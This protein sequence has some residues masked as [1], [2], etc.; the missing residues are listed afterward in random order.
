M[1]AN[2]PTK[3]IERKVDAVIVGG[4]MSGSLAA[5]LL[6]L[7]GKSVAIVEYRPDPREMNSLDI[8]RSVGIVM[9]PRGNKAILK[10]DISQEM[11][12][13]TGKYV[14][15]RSVHPLNGE[16]KFVGW[17]GDGL[18]RL[19]A[20]DRKVFSG[21]LSIISLTTDS[22]QIVAEYVDA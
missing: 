7:R 10:A 9:S 2:H 21:R 3:N 15:T 13:S 19:L 17:G 4:G 11:I 20:T 14:K 8:D 5:A 1:T 6:S 18:W 16:A 22:I 12:D